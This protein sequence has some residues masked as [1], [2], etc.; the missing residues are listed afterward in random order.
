M[1]VA[2]AIHPDKISNAYKINNAKKLTD[3]LSPE[4]KE[5]LKNNQNIQVAVKSGWMPI[6]YKSESGE[7]QG[8]SVDY[9]HTLADLLQVTF[10]IVDYT[11]NIT[12]DE[13][14]IISGVSNGNLKN[15]QFQLLSR[16][17][18][19]FPLAIYTNKNIE[20]KSR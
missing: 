19:T 6:E 16:P 5:W 20:K 3:R 7:H 12:P 2:E 14:D 15:A 8:V 13:A 4:E 11:D 1:V 17:Y 9:F 10:I 18:I